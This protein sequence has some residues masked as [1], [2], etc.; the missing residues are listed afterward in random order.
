MA[1]AS[2]EHARM[3]IEMTARRS[4]GG[5][6]DLWQRWLRCHMMKAAIR[7]G[8]RRPPRRR[9]SRLLLRPYREAI[10]LP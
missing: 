6:I 5:R 8:E 7:A 3:A 2:R 4:R 10:A 9:R 1:V